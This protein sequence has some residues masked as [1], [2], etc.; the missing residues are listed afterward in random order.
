[1]GEACT[2]GTI[3]CTLTHAKVLVEVPVTMATAL[4]WDFPILRHRP[5]L[6]GLSPGSAQ[7]VVFI[8]DRGTHRDNHCHQEECGICKP[9]E[10]WMSAFGAVEGKHEFVHYC[11]KMEPEAVRHWDQCIQDLEIMGKGGCFFKG[12]EEEQNTQDLQHHT[13]RPHQ[14]NDEDTCGNDVEE[15]KQYHEPE[16]V[17]CSL[18][19]K[20]IWFHVN[21]TTERLARCNAHQQKESVHSTGKLKKD[22]DD[23][24]IQGQTV[25]SLLCFLLQVGRES[26]FFLAVQFP[27]ASQQVV[28]F[29]DARDEELQLD[30]KEEESE[31]EST[32]TVTNEMR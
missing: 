10:V 30:L 11:Y 21:P 1:M 3:G 31:H 32:E 15:E 23:A 12:V 5:P 9:F 8:P 29:T 4:V 19:R 22:F 18:G 20:F 13:N 28:R 17:D 7:I 25:N 26:G 16:P 27:I 2:G 14:R 6:F 24:P